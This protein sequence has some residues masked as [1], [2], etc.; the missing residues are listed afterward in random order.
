MFIAQSKTKLEQ[1]QSNEREK[2]PIF[3]TLDVFKELMD[4]LN[5]APESERTEILLADFSARVAAFQAEGVGLGPVKDHYKMI[6]ATLLLRPYGIS[7]SYRRRFDNA[8]LIRAKAKEVKTLD[9]KDDDFVF[10]QSRLRVRHTP[11]FEVA[12]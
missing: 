2:S 11:N 8:L 1:L 5:H 10:S 4:Y 9:E 7:F 6:E 12:A 3:T